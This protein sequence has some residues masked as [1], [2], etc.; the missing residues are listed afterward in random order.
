MIDVIERSSFCAPEV[1]I[2]EAVVNWAKKNNET[3]IH[4]IILKIR[5]PLVSRVTPHKYVKPGFCYIVLKCR[6]VDVWASE[7]AQW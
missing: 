1:D 5:F 2:F 4:D 7:I 3:K 6:S